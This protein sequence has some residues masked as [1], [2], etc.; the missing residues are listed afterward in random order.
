MP[1]ENGGDPPTSGI[2]NLHLDPVTGDRVSKSEVKKRTKQ[3]EQEEKKQKKAAQAPPR[4]EKKTSTKY[5]EAELN[6]N[7]CERPSRPGRG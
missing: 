3:R 1:Q 6:P 5:E 4:P 2:E 7:V